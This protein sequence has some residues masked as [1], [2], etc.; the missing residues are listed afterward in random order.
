M[1]KNNNLS[2][3]ITLFLLLQTFTGADGQ[4][5]TFQRD[6]SGYESLT[7]ATFISGDTPWWDTIF[8]VQIGFDFTYYNKKFS[9]VYLYL[10][11]LT[12][13]HPLVEVGDTMYIFY[14]FLR[15]LIDMGYGKDH[16]LSP[17]KYK[18]D[19]A[20][21]H[22]IF[23]IEYENAHLNYAD[24]TVNWLDYQMWLY[25]YNGTIEVHYGPQNFPYDSRYLEQRIGTSKVFIEADTSSR[26]LGQTR[27]SGTENR[28][29]IDTD[30]LRARYYSFPRE[31][32]VYRFMYDRDIM[33]N[34][35]VSYELISGLGVRTVPY[36]FGT[37]NSLGTDIGH[38]FLLDY[39]WA[40]RY[41]IQD[42]AV[43]K[44][45]AC[46]H[47]GA[48]HSTDSAYY[49]IYLPGSDTLPGK[50]VVQRKV[51][52]RDLDLAGNL[53]YYGFENPVIL[54]DTFYVAFGV[55]PYL[56]M[57]N[58]TIGIYY[59]TTENDSVFQVYGRT[60]ARFMDGR[61]YDMYCS[62]YITRLWSGLPFENMIHLS[63]APVVNFFTR[64]TTPMEDKVTKSWMVT[65]TEPSVV[66]SSVKLYPHYPNPA[67]DKIWLR[68]E[69]IHYSPVSINVYNLKGS[70]VF[71]SILE[72][73]SAGVQLY[74]LDISDWPAGNY[75]YIISSGNSG[76]SSIFSVI[77]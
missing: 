5:Y 38:S 41:V 61:W 60:A 68:F 4:L 59:T 3:L 49:T 24:D 15:D 20:A 75:L 13:N 26:I 18:V 77:R 29:S 23:K 1:N 25:E 42:S 36:S 14:T 46:Q 32:E 56:H 30:S 27:L 69:V 76:L 17:I 71:S 45:V 53:K 8:T 22:R 55:P 21:G 28:I 54:K 74:E 50:P 70:M 52:F 12:F 7:D 67:A 43:I 48:A 66:Y 63:L 11:T 37:F 64:N 51:C 58:D 34:N 72:D 6:S 47:Y 39:E 62:T 73:V 40:E 35:L 65:G 19:G 16:S 2:V 9:E 33:L 10:G 57:D 44:G 31:N